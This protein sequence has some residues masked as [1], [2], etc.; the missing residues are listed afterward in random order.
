VKIQCN[1]ASILK[2]EF[3]CRL[4]KHQAWYAVRRY[5]STYRRGQKSLRTMAAFIRNI[6]QTELLTHFF[7]KIK[8]VCAS[9]QAH[10]W[11]FLTFV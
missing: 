4:T 7:K 8:R 5:G 6:P 2:A 11:P 10:G 1:V 9:V 3:Y